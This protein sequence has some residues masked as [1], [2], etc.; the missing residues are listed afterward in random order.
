MMVGRFTG[1]F[2]MRSIP[3]ETVL[4]WF[5]VGAFVVMIVT[6]FASG[7][8]AMWSLILVGLF[9]SLMFP[10]I[11]TLGIK[12]LGPLTEEGSSLLIMASPAALWSSSRAGSPTVTACRCRSC[13]PPPAS[14]MSCST[15]C[16]E[17]ADGIDRAAAAALRTESRALQ[18][19][20][21]DCGNRRPVRA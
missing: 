15:L 13:S 9:H 21:P 1:A 19:V 3:A 14:S 17:L 18:P 16:G 10:T 4:A 5:S 12:G 6:V 11:F 8:L 20:R 2:L 7:P